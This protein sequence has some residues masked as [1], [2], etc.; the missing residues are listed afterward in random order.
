MNITFG[1][2]TA[3]P[4]QA[5]ID[6]EREHLTDT[7]SKM[8]LWARLFSVIVIVLSALILLWLYSSSLLTGEQVAVAIAVAIVGVVAIAVAI[9]VVGA[10]TG[11]AAVA[12][13][14]VVAAAV[15][16]VAAVAVAAVGA[17]AVAGAVAA[18][19][20]VAVAVAVAAA[21]FGDRLTKIQ[22]DLRQLIPLD[23]PENKHRCVAAFA[24]CEQDSLCRDYAAAVA[25]QGR[26]LVLAEADLIETWIANTSVRAS[27][28]EKARLQEVAC[29][30]LRKMHELEGEG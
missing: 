2:N 15:A 1:L 26:P 18:A 22:R 11:T 29:V 7:T 23:A 8:K 5:A 21:W 6:Q 20:A 12:I 27:E 9:A 28:E 14:G 16:A 10:V 3:P 17:A 4:T 25:R 30:K 24:A 19:V 13:V